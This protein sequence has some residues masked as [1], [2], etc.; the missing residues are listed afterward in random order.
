MWWTLIRD[1]R[2]VLRE[3][4]L[5]RSASRDAIWGC[6]RAGSLPGLLKTRSALAT[7]RSR[8]SDGEFTIA[9]LER[10]GSRAT[11]VTDPPLSNAIAS[12]APKRFMYA[13]SWGW[14]N[15]MLR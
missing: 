13:A 8:P 6:H 4:P 3:N 2:T 11:I 12:Y 10:P 5:P 7:G 9:G 15:P 1:L 14:V